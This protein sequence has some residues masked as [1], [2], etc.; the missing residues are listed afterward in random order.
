LYEKVRR[1]A[2]HGQLNVKHQHSV[3]GRNSRLDT[4]QAA[5]LNVKLKYLDKWNDQRKKHAQ[6]YIGRL[7]SCAGITLP[8]NPADR[9]HVYHLFVIRTGQREKLCRIFDE[10]A[11]AWSIHYPSPLPFVE[12]YAYK[13]HKIEEFQV[14]WDAA[15]EIIS[16][17]LYP[18]MSD[19]QLQFI[20]DLISENI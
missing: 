5:V 19:S 18:E 13:R 16:I 12:A 17:P 9:T 1:I 4:M 11:V 6:Q 7:S 10:N 3:T 8:N 20:S 14:S 15:R 2:N